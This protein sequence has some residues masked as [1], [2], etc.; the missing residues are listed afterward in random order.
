MAA[1]YYLALVGGGLVAA[2]IFTVLL[3]GIK[4]I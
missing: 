3:R 1:A 4:L 2:F